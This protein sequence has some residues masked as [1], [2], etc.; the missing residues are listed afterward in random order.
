[1][2]RL[3]LGSLLSCMLVGQVSCALWDDLKGGLYGSLIGI[4][5]TGI[6]GGVA[7]GSGIEACF[8]KTTPHKK[9]PYE[10]G[11]RTLACMTAGAALYSAGYCYSNC[12]YLFNRLPNDYGK[13]QCIV[14]P[15]I[16]ILGLGVA[17]GVSYYNSN[18]VQESNN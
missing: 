16:A 7:F 18:R 3:L 14:G 8:N 2:K 13:G 10:N 1:M 6:G 5:M 15:A 9:E 17:T 12:E 11:T 4:V